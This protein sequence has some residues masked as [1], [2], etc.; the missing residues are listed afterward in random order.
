LRKLVD[1][2]FR[3]YG[4]RVEINTGE[5]IAETRGFVHY[6][7]TTARKHLLPNYAPLGQIPPGHCRLLLPAYSVSEGQEV[8]YGSRWYIVRQVERV[9][10]GDEAIY[11]RCLCEE[12]GEYDQWGK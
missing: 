11:D 10:L 12:R 5:S 7:A 4:T 9:W 2:I 6:S 8:S 3:K 1:R